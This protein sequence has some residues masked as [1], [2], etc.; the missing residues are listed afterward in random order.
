[1]FFKLSGGK[2][3]KLP[4]GP[5]RLPIIGSLHHLVG[6][7]P[8]RTITELC[9]RHGPMMYLQLGEV[10]TVVV[11]GAE[12]VGQM[13]KEN[14][15]MFVNRRTTEMQDI[16]GSGGK[17]I[18]FAPYG[19]HWRQMRKVC[20]AQ[21]LSSKQV[22]RM[23][24][25]RAEELGSLLRFIT[26]SAGAT[27]NISQKLTALGNDVVARAVFGGKF[28]QQEAFI[29]AID[30]I[31][32]LLGGFLLVDLFPSSRLVRW[33]SNEERRIKSSCD[34]V[35][36][37]ITDIISERKVVRAASG[38]TGDECLLDVML[39]LQEDDSLESPL[40]T[41]MIATVLFVSIF[42]SIAIS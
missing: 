7:L 22:K 13:M 26:A 17:G 9:H 27:M 19:D 37:I 35:H 34:V 6:I 11:S 38:G 16:V 30:H 40:T 18:L 4:P 12:A 24:S 31:S 2:K 42:F 36:R 41:E 32:D 23:E 20:V 10:P 29:R 21:L 15:A 28:S 3:Q 5:W 14:E 33:L 39:T 8:H 25:V 1:M